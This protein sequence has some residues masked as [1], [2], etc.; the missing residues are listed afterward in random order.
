[1][2]KNNKEERDRWDGE[3]ETLII[4]QTNEI[5]EHFKNVIK[6]ERIVNI[7]VGNKLL[8]IR[9]WLPNSNAAKIHS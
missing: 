7:K 1:M 9:C 4:R 3:I 8:S 6:I 2:T 5:K